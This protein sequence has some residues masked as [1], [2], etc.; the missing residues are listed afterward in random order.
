MSPGALVSFVAEESGYMEGLRTEDTPSQG[1]PKTFTLPV[2]WKKM[3]L[4][5]IH[6]PWTDSKHLLTVLR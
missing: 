1:T 3:R 5:R 2:Q 6:I 4:K